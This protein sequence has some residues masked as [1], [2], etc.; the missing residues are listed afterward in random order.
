MERVTL[1]E[2]INCIDEL[3]FF[4]L[5]GRSVV[6]LRESM[7]II[8]IDCSYEVEKL[9]DTIVE[10]FEASVDGILDSL[11]SDECTFGEDRIE[12][13]RNVLTDCIDSFTD[14]EY[15]VVEDEL[16]YCVKFDEIKSKQFFETKKKEHKEKSLER[17]VKKV[18]RNNKI[19]ELHNQG[20]S[21]EQIS[22]IMKVSNGT[23]SNVIN[24]KVEYKKI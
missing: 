18:E 4:V 1:E 19:I 12:F 24:M 21:Y 15:D 7:D 2:I 11:D 16:N 9:I 13:I 5:D 10:R 17:K 6:D 14:E 3:S 22:N 8:D 23:I 20:K